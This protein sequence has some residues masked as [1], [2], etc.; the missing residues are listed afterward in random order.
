MTLISLGALQTVIIV[1]L[2]FFLTLDK[3]E[4]QGIG[5]ALGLVR[6]PD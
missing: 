4:R 6:R 5:H 1:P 2:A 3:Q